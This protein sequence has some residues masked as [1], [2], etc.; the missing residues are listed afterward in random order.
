MR[1]VLFVVQRTMQKVIALT[2]PAQDMQKKQRPQQLQRGTIND[3]TFEQALESGSKIK[4]EIKEALNS[5]TC[6]FKRLIG[7]EIKA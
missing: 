3:I 4:G 7:V 2:P 6:E 5:L 1:D